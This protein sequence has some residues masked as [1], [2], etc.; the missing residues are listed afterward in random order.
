MFTHQAGIAQAESGVGT[1]HPDEAAHVVEH[2]AVLPLQLP[3]DGVDA[4]GAVVGIMY[5]LLVA[6]HFVARE[7]ER[8]ALRGEHGSLGQLVQGLANGHTRI[9][10]SGF[11]AIG[12]AHVVVAAHVAD[13]LGGFVGPKLGRA[14]RLAEVGLRML[15]ASGQAE[16][17]TRLVSL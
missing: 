7:D 1:A 12:Q 15:H 13:E 10:H 11:Q 9:G 3:A 16:A 8:H 5:A 2:V 4:V 17:Y 14:A 6:H